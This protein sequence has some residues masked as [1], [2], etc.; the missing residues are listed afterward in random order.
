V[1]RLLLFLL[2]CL[3]GCGENMFSGSLQPV[4]PVH[5]VPV[6]VV[7]AVVLVAEDPIIETKDPVHIARAKE[8]RVPQDYRAAMVEALELAGLKVAADPA[9][10]HDLVAKLALAVSEQGDEIRQVYRC[11]LK[12]PDG[13]EVAQIDWAWP[14]GTF[15][16]TADVYAF[17]THNLATEVATS[18]RVAE[19]LRTSRARPNK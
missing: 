4:P 15:V 6:D 18:R 17:A 3:A 2:L 9:Q 12:G 1:K 11:G 5:R 10:P 16:A 13:S 19:Y 7:G 8:K 14:K